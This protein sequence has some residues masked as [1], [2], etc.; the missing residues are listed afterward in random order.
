MTKEIKS[1]RDY[2][3]FKRIE[4]NREI[5]KGH[6]NKLRSAIEDD[7]QVIEYN[8]ILVNERYQIID[9]QHRFEAIKQLGLPVYYQLIPGLTLEN[10]QNLNSNSKQW[11]PNDYA[12]AFAELGDVNYMKY[13]EHRD[14]YNFNHEVTLQYVGV[15]NPVTPGGFKSGKFKAAE[16]EVYEKYSDWLLQIGEYVPHYGLRATAI[17]F[18][19]VAQHPDYDHDRM[20]DKIKKLGG[21]MERFTQ[22][23]EAVRAFENVYNHGLSINRH[24]RFF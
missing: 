4:G 2:V 11:T 13:L 20:M 7:P 6:V 3:A 5:R 17:A 24:I 14:K 15:G 9:G 1:T 12:K 16:K 18:V 21:Q 19:Q 23:H 8:P 22:L 10:V